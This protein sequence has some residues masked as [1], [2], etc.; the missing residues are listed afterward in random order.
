MFR[1]LRKRKKPGPVDVFGNQVKPETILFKDQKE[2]KQFMVG[3]MY[4]TIVS[5]ASLGYS[6]YS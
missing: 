6:L 2:R 4:A 3:L 1:K 5:A